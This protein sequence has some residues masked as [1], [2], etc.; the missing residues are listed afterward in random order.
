MN[1]INS[2]IVRKLTILE[3]ESLKEELA[4]NDYLWSHHVPPDK[5]SLTALKDGRSIHLKFDK[6]KGIETNYWDNFPETVKIIKSVADRKSI[7]RTYWHRLLPNDSIEKHTDN[8]VYYVKNNQIFA[9]YQIYLDVPEDSYLFLDDRH[10]ENKE[11]F[12]NSIVNFNL[13]KYHAYKNNS[14]KAWYFLVFDVM[15]D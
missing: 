3:I 1:D 11:I 2:S 13:R 9:R 6:M 15:K 12:S 8:G 10:I 4:S 7:E 5:K 14:N